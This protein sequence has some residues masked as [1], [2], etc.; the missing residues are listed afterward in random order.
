MCG[1]SHWRA[2]KNAARK[3]GRLDKTGLET[4][5]CRH[6]PAQWAVNMYRGEIYGYAHFIHSKTMLPAG[7]HYFTLKQQV[8]VYKGYHRFFSKRETKS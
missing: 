1:E 6:G 7:V 3:R 4:V 8:L 2:A 5:G